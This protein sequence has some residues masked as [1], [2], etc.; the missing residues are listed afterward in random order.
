MKTDLQIAQEATLKPISE[1]ANQLGIDNIEPYGHYM[2]KVDIKDHQPKG[3]LV[4]VSAITPTKAGEGKSTTTVGL[5]DSLN[6]IGIKA[7]GAM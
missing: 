7:V 3:K 5:V 1:I 6:K 4:L 2:A